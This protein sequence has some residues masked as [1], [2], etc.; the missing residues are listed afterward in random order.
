MMQF[1]C[2]S[3]R[4]STISRAAPLPDDKVDL[5][6]SHR[7]THGGDDGLVAAGDFD[8]K[9]DK[10][11]AHNV[12]VFF[13]SVSSS[14]FSSLRTDKQQT[15]KATPDPSAAGVDAVPASS[16][17]PLSSP[18]LLSLPLPRASSPLSRQSSI[19]S[20]R[21]TTF[22]NGHAA[23]AMTASP[24]SPPTSAILSR[25]STTL[26]T[27][28]SRQ[29]TI[30]RQASLAKVGSDRHID[31]TGRRQTVANIKSAELLSSP[32]TR[33][34]SPVIRM[35][36][37]T[38]A[39]TVLLPTGHI[40]RVHAKEVD[41]VD[42]L[43]TRI[44]SEQPQTLNRLPSEY[45]IAIL[46]DPEQQDDIREQYP[47]FLVDESIKLLH[48][49]PKER[50]LAGVSVEI[51]R[52]GMGVDEPLHCQGRPI[53]ADV[54][55]RLEVRRLIGSTSIFSSARSEEVERFQTVTTA[56]GNNIRSELLGRECYPDLPPPPRPTRRIMELLMKD[57]LS[58]HMSEGTCVSNVTDKYSIQLM[59][60]NNL[61]VADSTYFVTMTLYYGTS[62]LTVQKTSSKQNRLEWFENFEFPI[63]I[64]NVP[65]A[66]QMCVTVWNGSD[67]I[68]RMQFRISDNNGFLRVGVLHVPMWSISDG[69]PSH[70]RLNT[71]PNVD[72]QAPILMLE[73]LVPESIQQPIHWPPEI[74]IL[75]SHLEEDRLRRFQ[76]FGFG[77]RGTLE[78]TDQ[79]EHLFDDWDTGLDE[80]E[81]NE[82]NGTHIGTS[83]SAETLRETLDLKILRSKGSKFTQT[84]LQ[85]EELLSR[86]PL[87]ELTDSEK[88][89]LWTNRDILKGYKPAL[90]KFLLAVPWGNAA[91]VRE[92]RELMLHWV[93]P[94]AITVLTLLDAQYGDP[95]VRKYAVFRL[96][97]LPDTD[98]REMIPQLTQ[99]LKFEPLNDSLLARL[100][101]YRSLAN[102]IEIGHFF[103]WCLKAEL[104]IA[105]TNERFSLLLNFFLQFCPQQRRDFCKQILLLDYLT[106]VGERIKALE[107]ADRKEA[108][109]TELSRIVNLLPKSFPLPLDPT[110][111]SDGI[112]IE[113]CRSMDSKKVPLW[114]VFKNEDDSEPDLHVIYKIGDDLRQD[115]LTIQVLRVMD[116]LWRSQKLDLL[117]RPYRC[118]VTGD[119][120]GMLEV[121]LE[122]ETVASITR[123]NGGAR[124]STLSNAMEA[125]NKEVIDKWLRLH[126]PDT[127]RKAPHVPYAVSLP[128]APQEWL[129][130]VK[131]E[132]HTQ[133]KKSASDQPLNHD[134]VEIE[135]VKKPVRGKRQSV[136]DAT[137]SNVLKLATITP[138]LTQAT[139]RRMAYDW[140][141]SIQSSP[142][143]QSVDVFVRSC[144]GYCV[145]SYVLGLGDR[146]NDNLMI[147]RNGRFFH[148]D[149]GHF[150]GNFKSKFGIKRE[151]APFVFTP[152]F[153][154][155]MGDL[156]SLPYK[157]FE[158]M[159]VQAYNLTRKYSDLFINLFLL[160]ISA[161]IPELNNPKDLLYMRGS[162]S[163]HLT[164]AEAAQHFKSQITKSLN[165]KSTQLND[166]FHMMARS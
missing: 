109:R 78:I 122:A 144:A 70:P 149:F 19:R 89:L 99:A 33:A 157:Q 55:E 2:G 8:E 63:E 93:P 107:K 6:H 3:R 129:N 127:Y 27:S 49:I 29:T 30:S 110:F 25:Q 133:S 80:T 166:A 43:K 26:M 123:G 20:V 82:I 74:S 79:H 142:Y 57:H 120:Q 32:R 126:N 58:A 42:Q 156:Q 10:S 151:R 44:M 61:S 162:L 65:I 72:M 76:S 121:V 116:K 9:G 148:I 137:A 153:L 1:C 97:E 98:F 50:L 140:S 125:F 104:H 85:I 119:K 88:H 16:L 141:S 102:P 86:D 21:S 13:S 45:V 111:F 163:T 139:G 60:I 92:A 38:V 113:S 73:I 77:R 130:R 40:I 46:A 138:S 31:L 106:V 68:Y 128:P 117:L 35:N 67:P 48:T 90:A 159:C 91:A 131:D 154:A 28:L 56:L 18:K 105:E 146:H 15:T 150:L 132:S 96:A 83:V 4:G 112:D 160:M 5:H 75:D 47:R 95:F 135:I 161:G 103:F 87:C 164:E 59:R 62:A 54:L 23:N 145:A 24:P 53:P 64:S 165:T 84:I 37:G 108:L 22:V 39:V 17:T 34:S 36:S 152:A 118:L 81:L 69:E 12:G 7:S 71:M 158:E 134:G 51:V 136:A 155:V 14:G 66:A 115:L 41:S 94:S 100:L 11:W 101:V 147:Q 143:V 114:I 52:W 124:R